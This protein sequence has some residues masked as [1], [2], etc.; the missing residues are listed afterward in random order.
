MSNKIIEKNTIWKDELLTG[1]AAGNEVRFF[2]AYT[3]GLVEEARQIHNTSPIATA[4]LGRTLTAG[5]MMGAMCKNDSDVLTLQLTGDGPMKGVTVT[6]NAAAEVKGLVRVPDVILPPNAVGHLNVG[7]A[8]GNGS[9]LV[10]KD[11]GLKDPYVGQ[12]ELVSGE[13]AEDLTYY[14]AASEQIPTSVGLGVL[15]NKENYVEHAGGFII[16]L[17]PFATEQTIRWLEEVLA[18]VHSVT[19]YFS[20]GYSIEDLV[21]VLLGADAVIER[22]LV[23]QY[24]CDCSR[25]R[26]EKALISLGRKE[27]EEMISEGNPVTLHCDFCNKDYT[28]SVEELKKLV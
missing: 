18:G 15:L 26:V 6:A 10:I 12:T 17:L 2:A 22:R 28:F 14:F 8:I 7:G 20:D 13:V 19:E 3:R 23:P 4:A 9:L 25:L 11:I 27:L 21:H 5:A 24:K 1:M 16:Q